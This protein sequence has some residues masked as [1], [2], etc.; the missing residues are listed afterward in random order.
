MC[1]DY[2]TIF[3]TLWWTNILPWK[4]PPFLMGKSTISMAIFHCYVSSPEGICQEKTQRA[5][6]CPIRRQSL[7]TIWRRT[8]LGPTPSSRD[9]SRRRFLNETE[10]PFR[11]DSPESLQGWYNQLYSKSCQHLYSDLPWISARSVPKKST[12]LRVKRSFGCV[13]DAAALTSKRKHGK[14]TGSHQHQ[15]EL[16]MECS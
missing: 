8:A 3:D 7:F 16:C 9:W 15:S 11:T 12:A 14:A 13:Q 10:P 5:V 4:D 2:H 6:A 1:E